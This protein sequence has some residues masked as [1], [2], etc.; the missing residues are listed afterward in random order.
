VPIQV[1]CPSCQTTLKTADSSAGKRAKCPKCGG[2]IEIPAATPVPPA[3]DEYALEAEPNPLAGFS[4][5]ELSSGP[6]A[7]AA[8]DRKPCPAC[9]EMIVRDAVKCRFCGE[10]FDPVLKKQQQKAMKATGEDADLSTGEWVVAILCSGIGCIIGI[11]WM[12]QGKP[13]GKKMLLVSL[14]VQGFWFIVQV[15]LAVA[16]GGR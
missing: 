10:V 4:D 8:N 9:G 2:I 16:G 11:I 1:T 6:A 7:P 3:A 14:A 5:E 13:K 12:I 15:L